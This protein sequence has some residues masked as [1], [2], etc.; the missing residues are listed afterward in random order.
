MRSS[1]RSFEVEV[2][3][4]V[5]KVSVSELVSGDLEKSKNTTPE[6]RSPRRIQRQDPKRTGEYQAINTGEVRASMHGL[7]KEIFVEKGAKVE[8]GQRLMI[9]E[10]MKMESEIVA[11]KDGTITEIA[12]TAG[13]TV[14][15]ESLLLKIG[16]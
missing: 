16:D 2:D 13:E 15:N 1:P 5:F 12:V 7:V 8:N 3:Q 14:D 11:L 9:F 10:A 6:K 4:R